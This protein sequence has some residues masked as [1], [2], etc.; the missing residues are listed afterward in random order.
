MR[1]SAPRAIT[2]WLS[3]IIGALGVIGHLA[4]VGFLTIYSFWI[5]VV[6]FVILL[7]GT[8]LKGL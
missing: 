4:N 2:W 8:M 7:L 5:V 3:L 1:F 6:G